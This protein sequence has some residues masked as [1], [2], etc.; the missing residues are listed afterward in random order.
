MVI[1][2]V[3]ILFT[4]PLWLGTGGNT[5]RSRSRVSGRFVV[6][7]RS[8]RWLSSRPIDNGGLPV[9]LKQPPVSERRGPW[10]KTDAARVRHRDTT[11]TYTFC[12]TPHF[13]GSRVLRQRDC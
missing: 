2:V 7:N 3:A 13:P 8:K 1:L 12:A 9:P 6:P 10:S 5:M 11:P 4:I